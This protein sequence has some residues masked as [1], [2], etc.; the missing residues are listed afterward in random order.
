MVME[1][2][3]SDHPPSVR[4]QKAGGRIQ[5]EHEGLRNRSSAVEGQG[6]IS[7]LAQQEREFTPL[8]SFGYIWALNG[9]ED[10]HPHSGG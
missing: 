10:A 4:P 7:I 2:K 5:S 8:L 1:A 9:L 3:K 6:R